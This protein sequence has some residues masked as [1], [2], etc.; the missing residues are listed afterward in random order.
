MFNN[1]SSSVFTAQKKFHNL[2]IILEKNYFK[3]VKA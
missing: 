2:E 3:K 1:S